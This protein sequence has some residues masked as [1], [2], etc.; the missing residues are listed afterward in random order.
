M[1]VQCKSVIHMLRRHLLNNSNIHLKLKDI[2]TPAINFTYR[3]ENP[4]IDIGILTVLTV[5]KTSLMMAV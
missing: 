1:N 2:F 4:V 3:N 5:E